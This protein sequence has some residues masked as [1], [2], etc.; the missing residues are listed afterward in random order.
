MNRRDAITTLLAIGAALFTKRV[1]ESKP[2]ARA[3]G[4]N[5]SGFD[6]DNWTIRI[7]T[8][9]GDVLTKDDLEKIDIEY[10][11]QPWQPPKYETAQGRRILQGTC[12]GQPIG[13]LSNTDYEKIS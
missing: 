11:Y 12:S 4:M 8:K 10:Q 6:T 2:D 13:I 1:A 9:S 7:E 3:V 5:M